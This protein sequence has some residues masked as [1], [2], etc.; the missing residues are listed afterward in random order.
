MYGLDENITFPHTNNYKKYSRKVFGTYL[1]QRGQQEFDL[2]TRI[3]TYTRTTVYKVKTLG[4]MKKQ[5]DSISKEFYPINEDI[6]YDFGSKI[7]DLRK[8]WNSESLEN[9]FYDERLKIVN[10][11]QDL[12]EK[13][14]LLY[15]QAL[16]DRKSLGLEIVN[17]CLQG[18]RIKLMKIDMCLPIFEGYREFVY[19]FYTDSK[20]AS[21]FKAEN[22]VRIG[23]SEKLLSITELLKDVKHQDDEVF[24]GLSEEA[25]KYYNNWYVYFN[26]P[27]KD[28][29]EA[30]QKYLETVTV[31]ERVIRQEIAKYDQ[32]LR[33]ADEEKQQ[34]LADA[35]NEKQEELQ[36]QLQNEKRDQEF[37]KE[38]EERKKI[39]NDDLKKQLISIDQALDAQFREAKKTLEEQHKRE[40]DELTVQYSKPLSAKQNEIVVPPVQV[41]SVV[42]QQ[43]AVLEVT[44]K[45]EVRA[46]DSVEVDFF[47]VLYKGIQSIKRNG[48]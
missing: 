35:E 5:F 30:R 25:Q 27:D 29:L 12:K 26:R 17:N 1:D 23:F 22:A 45:N 16:E 11:I 21:Q 46:K 47:V 18:S 33:D 4:Y 39:H 36:A 13:I 2:T 20:A 43:N 31:I 32:Y 15:S 42:N 14:D 6:F 40:I 34:I 24:V 28:S 37:A 44:H 10:E 9:R 48:L 7:N 19:R 38:E 8:L 3:N 41:P